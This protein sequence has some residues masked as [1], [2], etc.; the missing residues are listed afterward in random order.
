MLAEVKECVKGVTAS[1]SKVESE[2]GS[3]EGP[4]LLEMEARCWWREEGD[5]DDIV[6]DGARGGVIL[7]GGGGTWLAACEK[8]AA[9]SLSGVGSARGQRRG[10]ACLRHMC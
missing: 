1:S 3:V 4:P 6:R 9:T 5:D 2:E 8:G 10:H 7:V